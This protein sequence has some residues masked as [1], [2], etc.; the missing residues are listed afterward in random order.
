MTQKRLLAAAIILFLLA[1]GPAHAQEISGNFAGGSVKVGYDSDT[2][3][4]AHD[5]NIRFNS[6]TDAWTFCNGSAWTT[7]GGGSLS[8]ISTQTASASAS[9]QWTGLG[10]SYT[11]LRLL[12]TNLVSATSGNLVRVQLGQGATP[13]W[14]TANS[15]TAIYVSNTTPGNAIFQSTNYS[16]FPISNNGTS[17]TSGYTSFDMT[18]YNMASGGTYKNATWTGMVS[19]N[20]TT[21][22]ET[23]YG[24]GNYNGNT[25]AITAVRVLYSAGNITSGQ[26]SLYGF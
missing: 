2:C 15:S 13:T 14:Q 9:L 17:S 25:T 1:V 16:G 6:S 26:C 23:S 8:L 22:L 11:Y 20:G 19:L 12:C 5:G 10:S 21:T 4:S 18:L 3:D 24:G 7:F